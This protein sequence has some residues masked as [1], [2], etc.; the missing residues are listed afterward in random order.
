MAATPLV[1]AA[2]AP[3]PR[4]P[5]GEE[6]PGVPS[7]PPRL[8]AAMR[9][10]SRAQ[11]LGTALG[12]GGERQCCSSVVVCLSFPCGAGHRAAGALLWH[13]DVLSR[14]AAAAPLWGLGGPAP[15]VCPK[16]SVG[17]G[18]LLLVNNRD[19]AREGL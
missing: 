3:C 8:M 14:G 9:D 16:V 2:C 13:G 15:S 12:L 7:V 18:G 1:A 19:L 5:L 17:L 4:S 6:H 10:V 11:G